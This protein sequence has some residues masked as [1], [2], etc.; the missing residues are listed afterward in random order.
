VSQAVVST[1]TVY[2]GGPTGLISTLVSS[3]SG[4][5][6]RVAGLIATLSHLAQTGGGDIGRLIG[7]AFPLRLLLLGLALVGFGL[8]GRRATQ[9]YMGAA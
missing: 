2:T 4:L 9:G 1:H 3:V 8:V 5:I 7:S 6:S